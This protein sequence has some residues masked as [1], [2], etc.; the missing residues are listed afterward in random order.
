LVSSGEGSIFGQRVELSYVLSDFTGG[1]A[2]LT[3]SPDGNEMHGMYRNVT[4]G[5]SGS[6]VLRR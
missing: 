2:Q 4:T 3:V 5:L 1:G 6:I